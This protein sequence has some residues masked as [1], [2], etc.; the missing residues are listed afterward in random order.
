LFWPSRSDTDGS[1]IWKCAEFC[2]SHNNRAIGFLLKTINWL[3]VS[4]NSDLVRHT[5]VSHSSL[6]IS[7]WT[8]LVKWRIHFKGGE[9][10]FYLIFSSSASITRKYGCNV[11]FISWTTR[12]SKYCNENS[13]FNIWFCWKYNLKSFFYPIKILFYYLRFK[14]RWKFD[15]KRTFFWYIENQTTNEYWWNTTTSK[16]KTY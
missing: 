1:F 8:D 7:V 9:I 10:R 14:N 12:S 16:R 4:Q 15:K 3:L 6:K 2:S 13:Y 5:G 11:L